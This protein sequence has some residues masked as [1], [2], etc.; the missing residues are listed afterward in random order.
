MLVISTIIL[1]VAFIGFNIHVN[2]G[3]IHETKTMGALIFR[4]TVTLAFTLIAYFTIT[5]KTAIKN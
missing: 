5:K 4:I 1:I 2:S 3:E